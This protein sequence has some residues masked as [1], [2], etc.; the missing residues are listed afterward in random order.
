MEHQNCQVQHV[1]IDVS[2]NGNLSLQPQSYSQFIKAS[3]FNVGMTGDYADNASAIAAGLVAGD[4]YRTGDIL[5]V[6][7]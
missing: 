2:A 1:L 5:K 7:H 3:S 6:V 4:V